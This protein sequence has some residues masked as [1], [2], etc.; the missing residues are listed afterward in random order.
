MSK[1][2]NDAESIYLNFNQHDDYDKIIS[3]IEL[4]KGNLF[5]CFEKLD[6]MNSLI[7]A[8]SEE[9]SVFKNNFYIKG[10]SE[11]LRRDF[12]I[13]KESGLFDYEWYVRKYSSVKYFD[14][15]P[16]IH[17]LITWKENMNDPAS[18]FSTKSY[19][20]F[21]ED[22][23][24]SGLNPF[25]H[26]IQSGKNEK[27]QIFPSERD[28]DQFDKQFM[29]NQ[30]SIQQ[31]V[32]NLRLKS[33]N[34]YKINVVFIFY[35][36]YWVYDLLYKLF[37]DDDMFNV[38][39]VVTPYGRY[40]SNQEIKEYNEIYQNFKSRGFNIIK[41]YDET[42]GKTIDLELE[43][44]PDIIF[45]ATDWINAFP[46]LLQINNIPQ[47][48]LLCYVPY[49][50]MVS[51][52]F[53][54]HTMNSELIRKC[55]KFFCPTEIHKQ[56]IVENNINNIDPGKIIVSYYPKVD[57]IFLDEFSDDYDYWKRNL[58]SDGNIIKRIIWAPHWTLGGGLLNYSTF[59]DNFRFFYDIAKNNP[60]IEWVFRPHPLLK[61][62]IVDKGILSFDETEDYYSSWD[63]LPNAK[64]YFGTDYASMYNYSDA[65]IT[66]SGS[67][68]GEYLICNKPCL[69]LDK[70]TQR[71]N[72]IG[73]LV[74][75]YWYKCDGS[76]LGGIEQFIQEVILSGNDVLKEDRTNFVKNNLVPK[77]NLTASEVIYNY[78]KSYFF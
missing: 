53:E 34:S 26:Y 77:G 68:L 52:L 38:T 16:I 25:V 72:E 9:F 8:N 61:K 76:N 10:Y 31:N 63:N 4:I 42:T 28:V 51:D 59:E 69:K 70:N 60:H 17:Y 66:D 30:L 74:Q 15:D 32:I 71:Y 35:K 65:M 50:F 2:E 12:K 43:C 7:C 20:L 24:K 75:N 56:K 48:A 47:T 41:G 73:D 46:K 57:G 14:I 55:W 6:E 27:R 45:Y 40:Y 22:V 36:S 33:N 58:D 19:Y 37:E 44:S 5:Q 67:F 11:E 13:I 49:S 78:I 23:R 1:K 54:S 21:H 39:L 62:A 64:Y 18:F 29:Y 3:E